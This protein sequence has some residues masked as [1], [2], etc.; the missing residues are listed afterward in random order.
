VAFLGGAFV[1]AAV[2]GFALFAVTVHPVELRMGLFLLASSFCSVNIGSRR[3]EVQLLEVPVGLLERRSI[4]PVCVGR[5][6][7]DE[8]V[9]GCR[10]RSGSSR[11]HQDENQRERWGLV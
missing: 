6:R 7:V 11:G 1:G 9:G 8:G 4:K 10:W 2:V 3:E 5:W